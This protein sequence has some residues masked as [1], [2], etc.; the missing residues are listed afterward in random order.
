MRRQYQKWTKPSAIN[1]CILWTG[2]RYHGHPVIG[3]GGKNMAAW[4]AIRI[5]VSG[6][7]T[8]K[9]ARHVRTCGYKDCVNPAHL[10]VT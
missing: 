6:I 1:D 9:D 5:Y 3:V 4:R 7:P 8:L 2:H 10:T